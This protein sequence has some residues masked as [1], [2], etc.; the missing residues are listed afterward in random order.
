M[1]SF[2]SVLTFLIMIHASILQPEG[3]VEFL[4]IDPRLRCT[5]N[6]DRF[7]EKSGDNNDHTSSSQSDWTSEIA[8]RFIEPSD[9]EL[10]IQFPNW[11]KRIGIRL[12]AELRPKDGIPAVNLKAWLQGAGSVAI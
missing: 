7:G 2:G 4:E 9:R 3:V 10:D 11:N 6:R 5:I 12:E 1:I 8:D